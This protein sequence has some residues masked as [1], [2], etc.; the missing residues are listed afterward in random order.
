MTD[1]QK[2]FQD[3]MI[4]L[5]LSINASLVILSSLFILLRLGS[6]TSSLYV[7]QYRGNRFVDSIE[8]GGAVTFIEFIVFMIFVAVF[9][10]ALSRRVYNIRRRFA[11]YILAMGTLLIILATVVSNALL[12]A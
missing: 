4:V 3:R 9:H 12:G 11:T 2:Y 8:S 10:F 7:I 1:A 6:H 5:L